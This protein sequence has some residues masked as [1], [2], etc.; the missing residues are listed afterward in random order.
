MIISEIQWMKSCQS[1]LGFDLLDEGIDTSLSQHQS[2]ESMVIAHH[3]K[4]AFCFHVSN[5][6]HLHH[7][8]YYL[9]SSQF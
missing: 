8:M 6:P 3:R 2:I 1:D 9:T 5:N 4:G 7:T